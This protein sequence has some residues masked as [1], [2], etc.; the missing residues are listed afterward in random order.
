MAHGE[1]RGMAVLVND[2]AR[3]SGRQTSCAP[4]NISVA[5]TGLAHDAYAFSH[6]FEAVKKS[7]KG[8]NLHVLSF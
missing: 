4:S 7:A 8:R 5:P 3:I 6:G 2:Q 1:S